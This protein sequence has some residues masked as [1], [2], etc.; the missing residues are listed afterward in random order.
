MKRALDVYLHQVLAGQLVQDER[1]KML[2]SYAESWLENP[3]AVALSHSLPLRR[4]RFNRSECRGFFAGVLPEQSQR[5][6]STHIT[7]PNDMPLAVRTANAS[8]PL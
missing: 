5:E 3:K 1:G 4:E 6:E 8:C 2:F 7:Y